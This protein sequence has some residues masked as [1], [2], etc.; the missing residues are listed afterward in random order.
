ML[1]VGWHTSALI[2]IGRP[3]VY[4]E[5]SM[6]GPRIVLNNGLEI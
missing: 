2:V 4:N 6:C 3:L 5:G 1:V